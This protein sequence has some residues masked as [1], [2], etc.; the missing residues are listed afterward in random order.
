LFDNANVVTRDKI[1]DLKIEFW[2]DDEHKDA[3]CS[4]K[5]KAWIRGFHTSN[6]SNSAALSGED[7]LNINH[8]LVVEFEPVLNQQNF[9]EISMSN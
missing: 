7:D 9:Q 8:L 4:Y 3:L 6:P 2:K 1:K 5:C